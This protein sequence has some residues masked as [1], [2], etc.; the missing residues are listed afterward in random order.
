[1]FDVVVPA[2][3]ELQVLA[4]VLPC[5]CLALYGNL[6]APA[7]SSEESVASQA[8]A[9]YAVPAKAAYF[10]AVAVAAAAVACDA[11]SYP[12]EETCSV[13]ESMQWHS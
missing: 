7:A 8:F 3:V 1:M 13:A 9:T 5:K 4:V 12:W 2:V 6:L 11:V 10:A